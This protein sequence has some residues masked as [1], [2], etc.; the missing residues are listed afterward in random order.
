MTDAPMIHGGE[1]LVA[2]GSGP[3]LV[4]PPT[5]DTD[6]FSWLSEHAAAFDD[7]LTRHGG[8]VLRD[9]GVNSVSDFNRVAR[10]LCPDLLD[11]VNRSTPR[12]RLGGKIYTATEY[13]A[14]RTIPL[15][16]ESSYADVWPN[17]IFF[18]SAVVAASGGETPVASSH[19]VYE[20]VDPA[21]RERFERVGVEYVRNYTEGIDL[22]WREVFQTDDRSAVQEFCHDHGISYAWHDG[23]PE[24]TTREHRPAT[25]RH[26]RTGATVWFNQAHLFHRT[27]LDEAQQ[28]ALVAEVGV[29]NLPRDS[30][31][32]D[33]GEIEPDV[34]T[35][36]R[37]A[38]E[39]EKVTFPWQVGDVMMLDNLLY[40]HG[41]NPYQGSRKIVVAM[42]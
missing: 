18:Y 38:Y 31:Y 22:S 28:R 37:A 39:A 11:Y 12:T 6:V 10:I 5:A 42:G 24:L 8:V 26:P 33:G 20:R 21:I 34:I 2:E 30:R 27:A 14:D 29:A 13:P 15:H 9:C 25:M 1:F 16:N 17:R 32:G 23:Q 36:I 40:A 35:H 19:G 7:L 41:R 4:R 3:V